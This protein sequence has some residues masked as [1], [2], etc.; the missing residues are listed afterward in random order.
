MKDSRD[1]YCPHCGHKVINAWAISFGPGLDGD[2][3][4]E[5]GNCQQPFTIWRTVTV[6]YSTELPK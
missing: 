5:C 3:E 6:E 1:P 4:W 2:I